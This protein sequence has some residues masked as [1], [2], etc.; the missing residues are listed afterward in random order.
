MNYH[1]PLI[2]LI[3]I[4]SLIRMV[5]AGSIELS[6][7]EV[8]YWTYALHLQWNYFDHPPM[9]ALLIRLFTGNLLVQQELFIR[10]G[11]IVCAAIN[12]WQI[13]QLGKRVKDEYTGWL[14]ACFLRLLFMA[15]Y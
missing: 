9:I 10:L 6:N 5:V 7:D 8:Y 13:Y 3:V 14:A 11:A 2:G 12:T 4:S 15:A 1:K